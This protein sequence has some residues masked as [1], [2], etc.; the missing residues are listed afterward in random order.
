MSRDGDGTCSLHIEVTTSDDDGNYTFM[1]ANPQVTTLS[2][3]KNNFK[4][5]FFHPSYKRHVQKRIV[6]EGPMDT[7]SVMKCFS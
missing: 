2:S 1:A 6:W 7:C 4:M 3:V 5:Y